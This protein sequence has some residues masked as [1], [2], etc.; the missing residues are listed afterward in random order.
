VTSVDCLVVDDDQM[1]RDRI[2]QVVVAELGEGRVRVQLAGSA[3]E[4]VGLL[5][6]TS[7]D[8]MVVDV[9]LPMRP[10]ETPSKDGGIRLLRQVG[11]GTGHLMRPAFIVGITGFTELVSEALAEFATY[12]WALLTY[13]P[14]SSRWEEALANQC[15]HIYAYKERTRCSEQAYLSDVCLIT[16]MADTE[17]EAVLRLPYA[18]KTVPHPADQLRYSEG[19]IQCG[20]QSLR[21][22]A[23]AASEV[24]N[25]AAAAVVAKAATLFRP[26]VCILVGICAGIEAEVG[27]I[28]VCDFSL[29]YESGKYK[30]NEGGE[31]I[32]LPQPHYLPASNRLLDA[33][34]QYKLDRSGQ[35]IS[36][37]ADWPGNKPAR[38]P[39]VHVGPV[40]SGAAVIENREIV[41]SLKFRD[42]KLVALE[43]ES[44]GFYL[45]CGHSLLPKP[46]YIMIKGVCDKARPPKLDEF[47]KYAA[48]LSARFTHDFLVAESCMSGGIFG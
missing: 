6:A 23:T 3:N 4:A 43:M 17:L 45:A 42:R 22:I 29:H 1:K 5:R 38:A 44:Y 47:Q 46:E 39:V 16:A 18:F 7:F 10:D 41:E 27:D 21:V 19:T 33:V 12:G 40:A 37:P 35:I 25:A 11:R 26:K 15:K 28:V 20:S 34:R 48:F 14:E 32:F 8:L 36:I 9:N 30:E 2:R 13:S 31:A 24:G